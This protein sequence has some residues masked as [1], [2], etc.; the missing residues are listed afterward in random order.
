MMETVK[1]SGCQG[2][3]KRDGTQGVF[4]AVKPL[5]L[6]DPGSGRS[7]GGGHSDPLQCSCLEHPVDR[8]AWWTTAYKSC[9]ESDMTEATCHNM[10]AVMMDTCQHRFI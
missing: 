4:R 9:K 5:T 10:D 2:L 3:R 7:P 1:T 8:G 6:Y